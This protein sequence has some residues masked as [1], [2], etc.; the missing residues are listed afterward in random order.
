MPKLESIQNTSME[1]FHTVVLDIFVS[2]ENRHNF[3]V[4]HSYT[5]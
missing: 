4:G 5:I 1:G 2:I 3:I